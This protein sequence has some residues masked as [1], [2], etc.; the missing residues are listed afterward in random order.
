MIQQ[1]YWIGA[2]DFK[3][4]EW[5]WVNDL[6]KVHFTSWSSRQP[7]NGSGIEDCAHIWHNKSYTWNDAVCS[8]SLGY[9]C[10]SPQVFIY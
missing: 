9:I 3:E 10:E 5:R 2:T 7:D 4:G 1:F 8:N 6:S